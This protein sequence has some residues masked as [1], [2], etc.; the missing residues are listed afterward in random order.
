MSLNVTAL[1]QYKHTNI[2]GIRHTLNKIGGLNTTT[3]KLSIVNGNAD[4]KNAQFNLLY[5]AKFLFATTQ[6]A[7]MFPKP[8]TIAR[9][10]TA[11]SP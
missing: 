6:F 2:A 8:D 4:R 1:K 11:P 9:D 7:S 10:V 3:P 5:K